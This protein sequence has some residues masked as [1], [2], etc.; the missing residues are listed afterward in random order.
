MWVG[1]NLSN[2][3]EGKVNWPHSITSI[4]QSGAYFFIISI[5]EHLL[6]FLQRPGIKRPSIEQLNWNPTVAVK[7]TMTFYRKNSLT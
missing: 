2:F 1:N 7:T 3:V 4:A 5:E 6:S